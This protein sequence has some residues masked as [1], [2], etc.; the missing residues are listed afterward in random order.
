MSAWKSFAIEWDTDYGIDRRSGWSIIHDGIVV[1]ELEPWLVVAIVK[2][3][4]RWR[5]WGARRTPGGTMTPGV[6]ESRGKGRAC[7]DHLT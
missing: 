7:R 4:V 5:R 2:A 6:L 1:V 3:F